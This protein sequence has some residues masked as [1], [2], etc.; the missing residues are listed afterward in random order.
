MINDDDFFLNSGSEKLQTIHAW[1][2]A[3]M[4]SPWAVFFGVLLRVSASVPPAVQ[5][6]PTIGGNASLNL[7]CAFVGKSGT[8]KGT[9]MKVAASA[10]PRSI[11]TLPIG[12]GQG[13]AEAFTKRNDKDN[14]QP[15]IF[16][17]P[18]IDTLT[19]LS[20]SPDSILRPTLKSLAMGEQLGQANASKDTSRDVK[21]HSYRA[22][23]S[24]GVQPGHAAVI[25]SDTS[26]GLPQRFLW[27]P[28][29]DPNIPDG[30]F[31]DPEPLTTDMPIWTPGNDGV[32]QI[33]YSVPEIKKSIR[34]NHLARQ[35]GD[36]DALDGHA[37]LTRCKVAALL[38][39]M[40]G[41]VEVTQWDWDQS[42]H[43]M[44]V[45]DRTRT[46]LLRQEA[47]AK[48]ER[49]RER[50][51]HEALRNEGRDNY[52][53]ESVKSSIITELT[54][55]GG[56]AS[57][58]DLNT[59]LGKSHRRKL[60]AQA[61]AELADEGRLVSHSVRRGTR[62][63]LTGGV[64]GEQPVQGISTQVTEGERIVQGERP[65]GPI[66]LDKRRSNK[67]GRAGLSCQKWWDAQI[68]TQRAQGIDR[69]DEVAVRQAGITA[70][71]SQNQL[72]VAATTK[73]KKDA[74]VAAVG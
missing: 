24:V 17:I 26:G 40:D 49:E 34:A 37:L 59:K 10:W 69:I 50:G 67:L 56:S 60:L 48:A 63:E 74:R 8:G 47:D 72:Y 3:R 70:G 1:A 12:S 58:S 71:Y 46:A 42:E 20:N 66:S 29:T 16:D 2:R 44:A 38:A 39:I 64:Q 52:Q 35:R 19:G 41:R 73:R 43:V 11:L 53:L 65:V 6:P 22:C 28:V 51:R 55:Q 32:V 25:F 33:V 13:I 31:P 62:Y 36:G 7:L 30:D 21:A 61:A 27:V 18:E 57:A 45:S 54:K 68:D 5:L 9:S 23:V 4:A 15:I 14:I